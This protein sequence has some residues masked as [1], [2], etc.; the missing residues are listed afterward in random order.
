M[1]CLLLFCFFFFR[2][3]S[4]ELL[5]SVSWAPAASWGRQHPWVPLCSSTHGCP[6][7]CPRAGGSKGGDGWGNPPLGKERQKERNR[8]KKASRRQPAGPRLTPIPKIPPQ[9]L[10]AAGCP[11]PPFRGVPPPRP[12]GRWV[13]RPLPRSYILL[14]S[15]IVA[16]RLPQP[17]HTRRAHQGREPGPG[18]PGCAPPQNL[19][20]C[21]TPPSPTPR[22]PP[23][24]F[25]I[26]DYTIVRS[27]Y[28]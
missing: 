17:I 25:T 11:R 22:S 13:G 15:R 24:C 1:S 18:P 10:R 21:M 23:W 20:P 9:C 2:T 5:L 28:R 14:V 16:S 3:M 7:Q 19:G 8:P 26:F 6:A 4:L 12:V 27:H